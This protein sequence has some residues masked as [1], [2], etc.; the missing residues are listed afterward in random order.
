MKIAVVLAEVAV[1]KIVDVDVVAP[2]VDERLLEL[3][4]DVRGLVGVFGRARKMADLRGDDHIGRFHAEL[5]QRARQ[6]AL[7]AAVAVDVGVVEVIHARVEA[8]LD[9]P[10]DF[11]FIDVGPAVRRAVDPVESAHRPTTKADFGNFDAGIAERA[12]FHSRS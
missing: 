6:H 12:I 5:F 7:G 4:P 8:D 10:H 1:M 9:R 2:K 3:M 11:I